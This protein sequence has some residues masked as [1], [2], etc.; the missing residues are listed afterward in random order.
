[1]RGADLRRSCAFHFLT[2]P[3]APSLL[4]GSQTYIF[5]TKSHVYFPT[6]PF[7][8]S[9]P[10]LLLSVSFA[11]RSTKP[12]WHDSSMFLYA[13]RHA[14]FTAN[15]IIFYAFFIT[16]TYFVPPITKLV[17]MCERDGDF[18]VSVQKTKSTR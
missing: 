8:N 10:D 1:M 17:W 11:M 15:I 16:A 18:R 2:L 5:L 3:Y 6:F 13:T 9:N 4:E 14:S 12:A 7:Q